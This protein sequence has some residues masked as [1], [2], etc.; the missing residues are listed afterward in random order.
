MIIDTLVLGEYQTNSYVL[1]NNEQAENCVIVDT[2]LDTRA[3]LEFLG[4]HRLSPTALV[5]THGHIDHI[6]GLDAM[7]DAF[8][9]VQV[10]IHHFDAPALSDS[11]RNLSELAALSF[12]TRDADRLLDDGHVIE[13]AG[14]TLKVIHTPGHSPGS[15]CLYAVQDGLLFTGDT[16]FADSVGRTDFVLANMDQL[17]KSIKEK[18]FVLPDQTICYPGHGPQTTIGWERKHNPYV[19]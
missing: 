5:L 2:G 6:A 19:R 15:V 11:S 8:P 14:L 3:L 17:V 10:S 1:R 9:S 7:R 13:E 18:L 12:C 4:Q 16:L